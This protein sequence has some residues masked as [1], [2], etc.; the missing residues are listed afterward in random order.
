MSIPEPETTQDVGAKDIPHHSH[1]DHH[2]SLRV[3]EPA[4][5]FT[6]ADQENAEFKLSAWRGKRPVV[7]FF[8][9]LDWSPTCSDENLCWTEQLD[10][11][12]RYAEVAAISVDSLWSHRAF[13]KQHGL[14]HRLLSDMQRSVSRAYGLL[15]EALNFSQ[16]ATVV[17]DK[18]GKTAWYKVQS[19]I[20]EP[21]DQTEIL[22][23]LKGLE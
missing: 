7:L 10:S 5:D 6:L 14:K 1:G 12:S 4:P 15:I 18:A 13:A 2:I 11:L 16:R 8:Y 20:S 3:G 9:P 21:R 23:I 22:E 17:I 19:N